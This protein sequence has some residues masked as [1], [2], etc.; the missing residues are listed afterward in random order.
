[1]KRTAIILYLLF[2]TSNIIAQANIVF[3]HLNTAN[4]LSYIVVNNMCVDERGNLWI[5][6]ANGLNMFNGKTTEK[7]FSSEYPQ[8]MNSSIV[9]VEC[10]SLNRIWVLTT[11]GHVTVLD[12]NRKFHRVALYDTGRFVRTIVL[13]KT[14]NGTI[15][16]YAGKGNYIFSN[17][18]IANTDSISVKEFSYLPLKGFRELRLK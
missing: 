2:Y 8:L 5:A 12:E 18:P 11:G 6:T 15:S 3:Q 16:L 1:M 9:Q 17:S 7:Y 4:G 14:H 13:L 10:D